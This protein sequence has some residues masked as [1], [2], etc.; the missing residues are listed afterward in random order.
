MKILRKPCVIQAL[1]KYVPPIMFV[2]P[3][4]DTLCI[5]SGK[6]LSRELTATLKVNI[7][8]RRG[9]SSSQDVQASGQRAVFPVMTKAFG[10][11]GRRDINVLSTGEDVEK[12]FKTCL[13]I[14]G[15]GNH[16]WK[17]RCGVQ[18]GWST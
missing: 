17:R 8:P 9:G 12:A 13:G 14:I 2:G 1:S 6:M 11:G 5:A 15:D 3:S 16:L 10:G 4:P 18:R 7:A